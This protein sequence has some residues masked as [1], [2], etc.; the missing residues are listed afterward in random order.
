MAQTTTPC[1]HIHTGVWLPA[2]LLHLHTLWTCVPHLKNANREASYRSL[3]IQSLAGLRR[4]PF[5]LQSKVFYW[6]AHSRV[7][8]TLTETGSKQMLPWRISSNILANMAQHNSRNR[9][10]VCSAEC[11]CNWKPSS[12]FP[13]WARLFGDYEGCLV[14][15][16]G[17]LC[18]WTR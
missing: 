4:T 5:L 2:P 7:R 16:A 12:Y 9:F 15:W 13:V 6:F 3:Q 18:V 8:A 10:G 11:S 1:K 17:A 14:R